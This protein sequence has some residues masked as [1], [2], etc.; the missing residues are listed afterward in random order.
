MLE[1]KQTT[2]NILFISYCNLIYPY[3]IN[4]WG[5]YLR[6]FVFYTAI[7]SRV[8]WWR[9]KR[10]WHQKYLIINQN[11]HGKQKV[12]FVMTNYT[13]GGTHKS[14]RVV[15]CPFSSKKLS[16]MVTCFILYCLCVL[17]CLPWRRQLVTSVLWKWGEG[18]QGVASEA[19]ART[20]CP[21]LP[22]K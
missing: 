20:L 7:Q 4:S 12:C 10:K 14:G 11:K 9:R 6:T 13:M 8:P 15:L 3:M 16:K 2:T 1:D 5:T 19:A 22:N 17:Y 21:K 18:L